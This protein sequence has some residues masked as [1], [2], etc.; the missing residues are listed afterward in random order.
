MF[1]M[2]LFALS[3]AVGV[4]VFVGSLWGLLSASQSYVTERSRSNVRRL[5]KVSA[6]TL[7]VFTQT[8]VSI[9]AMFLPLEQSVGLAATAA[10]LLFVSQV[11]LGWF[12][13]DDLLV[14]SN[15]GEDI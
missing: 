13:W 1:L 9:I 14:H 3:G 2:L 10:T 5:Y 11:L 4:S 12:V 15:F 7:L 8:S 6:R